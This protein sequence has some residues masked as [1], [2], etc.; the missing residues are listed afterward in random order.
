MAALTANAFERSFYREA[1]VLSSGD[2]VK[3]AVPESGLYTITT[4]QLRQWGFNDPERVRVCGYGGARIPDV[5]SRANFVDD[6]PV[7]QTTRKSNGDIVFYGVGPESW[8]TAVTGRFVRNSNIYTTEG[9]YFITQVEAGDT[10]LVAPHIEVTGRP[11]ALNPNKV[12]GSVC[13]TK[14]TSYRP[15]KPVRSLSVRTLG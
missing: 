1:S 11:T 3:V 13:T 2:W 7:V 12:F 6:L 15:A 9:Y 14:K 4:A 8:T 5:M 10:T